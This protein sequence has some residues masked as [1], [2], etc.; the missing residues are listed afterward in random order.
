MLEDFSIAYI[1][2]SGAYSGDSSLF[3]YLYNKLTA[4]AA[5]RDLLGPQQKNIVVYHDPVKITEESRSKISIG[6]SVPRDM[7][8]SRDIGK[9]NF[10]G[11]LYLICRFS[12]RDE[13]Y[14]DA[15]N[16]VYRHWLPSYSL[17]PSEGFV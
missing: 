5:S 11:G 9:M 13:D 6:L 3:I 10:N 4:W 2:H 17:I 14:R 8:T 7:E 15:W 16:Q 1:R 12:L